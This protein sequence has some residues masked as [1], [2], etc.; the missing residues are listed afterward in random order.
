MSPRPS[1]GPQESLFCHAPN[2]FLGDRFILPVL[3][4]L[5]ATR[6]LVLTVFSRGYL[7]PGEAV[8]IAT[9]AVRVPIFFLLACGFPDF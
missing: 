5:L 3:S 2:M 9:L 4:T 1:C 8:A 7:K 6:I